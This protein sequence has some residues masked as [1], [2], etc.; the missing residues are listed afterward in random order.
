[1]P[2]LQNIMLVENE[3]DIREIE[4]LCLKDLGDFNITACESGQE[5]LDKFPTVKPQ[6]IL[7]DV[8]MPGLNGISTFERL[9]L[10]PGGKEVAVVFVTA[11]AHP[12]QITDYM[13]L[14]AAGVIAKPFDPITIIKEI[15]DI[16][17][18]FHKTASKSGEG[19]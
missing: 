15:T 18:S 1:M 2:A 19:A 13:K 7:L 5:A 4:Q 11:R 17:D 6:L 16:W 8:M 9:K 12:T 10:L 14:G 3:E